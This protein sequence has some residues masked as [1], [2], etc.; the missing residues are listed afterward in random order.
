MRPI[1]AAL[2]LAAGG[3][4]LGGCCA[5]ALKMCDCPPQTV[6]QRAT[7][8][9]PGGSVDYLVE[10]FRRRA[11]AEVYESLHPDFVASRGGF[12]LGDFA[13]AFAYWED[14]FRADAERLAVATRDP[15][16]MKDGRAWIHLS[17]GDASVWLVFQNRPASRVLLDDEVVQ[18][19]PGALPSLAEAVAV[20][21]D[22]LVLRRPIPLQG[23]GDM[24]DPAAV[25]RVEL[26]QD[27]LLYEIVEPRNI[28]FVD[29]IRD[30]MQD[31]TKGAPR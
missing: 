6:P 2:A 10:A 28:R 8:D 11:P 15:V 16:Q 18:E 23:L 3:A 31:E 27:W 5:L 4:P 14:D 9:T 26:F 19:I 25:R 29:R 22:G 17:E 30:E 1:L 20:E 21:G 12:S 7:R 24:V 13:T